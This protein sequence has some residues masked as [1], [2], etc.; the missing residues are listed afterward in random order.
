MT[1][2]RFHHPSAPPT[3]RHKLLVVAALLAGVLFVYGQTARHQF[4]NYD[5][6]TYVYNN[7]HVTSGL[8]A[9]NF[10]WAFQL[11][12]LSQW[13]PLTW[14]SHQLDCQLFG[15]HPRGHHL[16]NVALH[17]GCA[18]VLF[19]ALLELTG[20]FW[21]SAF[22]AAVFAVHPLN[23]ESVAWIAERKNLLSGLFGLLA[24]WA[25]ALYAKK[26]GARPYL[27]VLALLALG[28]MA[29][30][31]IAALPC[32]LLLLDVWPLG[33]WRGATQSLT[34]RHTSLKLLLLEKSPMLGLSA[35]SCLLT[36]WCLPQTHGVRSLEA[37]G[38]STR[39]TQALLTYAGY[40]CRL[41]WPADLSLNTAPQTTAFADAP[42]KTAAAALLLAAVTALAVWLHRRRPYLAVGWLWYLGMLLPMSGLLAVGTQLLADR[43]AYLPLIGVTLGVTWLACGD[44]NDLRRRARVLVPLAGC[45]LLALAVGA[46][47]QA[48][49]W[50]DDFAL[51]A[52]ALEVDAD[53]HL[54]RINLG[55]ALNEAGRAEEAIGHFR[56]AA[57]ISPHSADAH[58]NLA[59][60]LHKVK[61]SLEALPHYQQALAIDPQH[62]QTHINLGGL[63]HDLGRLDEAGPRLE[64]ALALDRKN[65]SAHYNLGIVR[66]KEQRLDDAVRHLQHAVAQRPGDVDALNNLGIALAMQGRFDLA[67]DCLRTALD[68][69]PDHLPTRRNLQLA[70][71]RQRAGESRFRQDPDMDI[72]RTSHADDE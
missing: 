3:T 59:A 7:D 61:R 11:N 52:R 58:R 13:H 48:A 23:V 72:L 65:F 41:V 69:N 51:F 36:I 38:W 63:L 60:T 30:P 46:R 70:L 27:L 19:L 66:L 14:M 71:A 16:H 33:R 29:K 28:L 32:A 39:L 45:V 5:D 57:R 53:D 17:A 62:V 20:A 49:H 21:P 22:V 15:T 34:P 8:S 1:H 42:W 25:Y 47:V 67:V 18:V 64:T 54:S 24:V 35:V 10:L 44:A 12:E 50:K 9:R 56:E 68:L 6:G 40:L 26:G 55:D 37:V 31:M 2:K 4:L 43:Y